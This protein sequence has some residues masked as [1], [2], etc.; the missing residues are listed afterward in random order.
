MAYLT[1]CQT[2]HHI[3]LCALI[4]LMANFVAFETK[5]RVA[6]KWV[7]CTFATEDAVRTRP[8]IWALFRHV[9]ELLA[10]TAFDGGIRLYVVPSH[11][12]LQPWEQ[13]FF[14][15][16]IDNAC[17][18]ISSTDIRWF[19]PL[20]GSSLLGSCCIGTFFPFVMVC[21]HSFFVCSVLE[22]TIRSDLFLFD[23]RWFPSHLHMASEVHITLDRSTWD[24]KVRIALRVDGADVVVELL[25]SAWWST[26]CLLRCAASRD[27]LLWR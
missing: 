22:L 27:R 3:R 2:L 13:V 5:L 19:L 9:A 17:I 18:I 25:G 11:L 15:L 8:L 10:I 1:A 26:R 7:M 4:C 12:V 14:T 20:K 6:F 21:W 23:L 24:N 16:F